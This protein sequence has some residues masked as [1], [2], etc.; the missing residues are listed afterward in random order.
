MSLPRFS[1]LTRKVM[2]LALL[3]ALGVAAM[4]VLGS[5]VS[6]TSQ[7]EPDNGKDEARKPGSEDPLVRDMSVE[8]QISQVLLL[9][10]EGDPRTVPSG[11][12][13][14]LVRA[15]NGAGA[16][17]ALAKTGGEIPPLVVASQE[18]GEYR[19]FPDLPPGERQLDIGRKPSPDASRAW[20]EETANALEAQGFHLN[21]FPVADIA[22]LDSPLAGRAFADDPELVTS[23]TK[24]ALEGCE[25]AGLTCAPLHFPGL[26]L[27]SQD[28]AQGPATISADAGILAERDLL[29][30]RAAF[31]SEASAVVVALGLYPAYD[32]IVPAALA[33]EV[34]TGLL[35]DELGFKGVAISDDL[36]A[37]AVQATYSTPDAAVEALDAGIDLIQ[38]SDPEKGAEAAKALAKAVKAG[39]VSSERLAEA[40][41]RVIRLKRKLGLIKRK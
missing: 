39:K 1:P 36:E 34:V 38:I 13:G 41:E 40:A 19:S 30:F 18:G 8:E 4:V 23:L 17:K 31:R 37:G 12:G 25:E 9:G 7:P 32:A 5:N 20:A 2:F 22:S 29:P 28:T 35:R 33:S 24:A 3:G 11:L 27:A 26:G 10:F 21:L 6:D 15:D 16:A 14:V